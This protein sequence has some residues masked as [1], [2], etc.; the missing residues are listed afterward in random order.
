MS[1]N[2]I[3]KASTTISAPASAVWDALTNPSLIKQY[4][5]GTDAVSDWKEGSA[6]EFKG[7]WN[8]KQYTDKGVILKSEPAKLFQYTY[9]SSFSGLPDVPE[10]YA[11]ITYELFEDNGETTLNVKQEN[12][13]N[14]DAR[15]HSEENWELVLKNLKNLLEK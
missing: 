5:F 9:L 8:G 1:A 7:E 11:N 2:L 15:K 3:A 10:N 6:L 4:F 12:V 13:A 14:E